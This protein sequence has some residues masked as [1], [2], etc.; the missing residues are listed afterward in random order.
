MVIYNINYHTLIR[1]FA[2][3]GGLL[4]IIYPYLTMPSASK[5][6]QLQ[7]A[8]TDFNTLP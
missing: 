4:I 8:M 2:E 7:S 6:P 1:T 3:V 5:A